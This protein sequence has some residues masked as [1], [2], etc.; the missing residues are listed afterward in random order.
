MVPGSTTAE[1]WNAAL[2]DLL[3]DEA[4][5]GRCLI[6][7]D[8]RVVRASPGWLEQAPLP[9]E[10]RPTAPAAAVAEALLRARSGPGQRVAV[11][12]HAVQVLGQEVWRDGSI[13]SVPTAEGVGLLV[14]VRPCPAPAL[15]ARGHALDRD[16]A[17][18]AFEALFQCAGIGIVTSALDGRVQACNPC[19]CE[20][21]GYTADELRHL[22]FSDYTHPEDLAA[23][24]A[25]VAR[26]LS[27]A[28]TSYR[29]E[30]R[31][32]HRS[33]RVVWV[34]FRATALTGLAGEPLGGLCL[35]EEITSRKQ[36]EAALR[37][38]DADMR[39]IFDAVRESIWLFDRE[40]VALAANRTALERWGRP[41]DQTIGRNLIA[42]L[43]PELFAARKARLQ[44]AAVAGHP[45][46][47]EDV[48]AGIHFEHTF[49]PV[50]NPDGLIDRIAV[51]SRD[52][53][54]QRRR[55]VAVAQSEERLRLGSQAGGFGT[56]T[57]DFETGV[58][59]WSPELVALW[60]R[61]GDPVTLDDKLLLEFL[62]PEDR[63]AF[64]AAMSQ[65]NDPSAPEDG[66][67]QF[68]YRILLPD[69]AIRWLRLRGRTTFTGEGAGRR[70]LRAAGAVTDI[71]ERKAQEA[72]L[73]A[74]LEE[75]QRAKAELDAILNALPHPVFFA[76][77]A[78]F[79]RANQ[80]GLALLGRSEPI[81]EPIPFGE[82]TEAVRLR[83]HPDGHRIEPER[84]VLKIGLDGRSLGRDAWITH[85]ATGRE[86]LL[87]IS[88]AP[89]MV[90]G[91]AVATVSVAIDITDQFQTLQ[92]L[93]TS[94]ARLRALALRL[95]RLREE[96]LASIAR[97]LHD[98]LAQLLSGL[99]GE[100]FRLEAWI[101]ETGASG[102]VEDW[103]V[104][105]T[106]LLNQAHASVRH[107]ALML[108]P[109]TLDRIG[110]GPGL[111]E[112]AR[113][114]RSRTGIA[115]EVQVGP[116]PGLQ[117][118]QV[119]A[120]YRIAQEALTNV[121][122]HAGASQVHLGLAAEGPAVVLRVADDGRGP[123]EQGGEGDGLGLLG[124]RE[125]A[126]RLGGTARLERGPGGGAVLVASLPIGAG[127]DAPHDDP[128]EAP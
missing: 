123:P 40:G 28:S 23:E 61:P 100:L 126:T 98:D 36:A 29:L 27:G 6:G 62:H 104:N 32:L 78:G 93:S 105:A 92:A 55:E 58:G 83:R 41:A 107:L 44:E 43:P 31:Y 22:R 67:L 37:A 118:E 124:M 56:Y 111:Q 46:Q 121:A 125:R 51:F 117:P 79:Q 72:R 59:W 5:V 128:T 80:A 109:T 88:G 16:A 19:F 87:R 114:F 90:D 120:L 96:E 60:E 116:L 127:S 14:S 4:G 54:E 57:Y 49:C 89:V 119:T 113:R 38:S 39:G 102:W 20:L 97:D 75:A 13:Q 76:G 68:D 69:G 122:R 50:A 17:A 8:G 95:E 66:V 52:V 33:G 11:R 47:F 9:P 63:P 85:P 64:L 45:I 42:Q 3:F 10:G 18:A 7:P 86:M 21:V 115:C 34:D 1:S 110:I 15:P 81:A 103:A 24:E 84:T 65:A 77:A 26:L 73:R 108:R 12:P 94:E 2:L 74:L 35:V 82:V 30:K 106:T 70:P 53:T 71:T 91:Q 48:R 25:L 101:Q 99:G 112:E